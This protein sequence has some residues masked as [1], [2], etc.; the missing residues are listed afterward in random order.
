MPN[1]YKAD[2]NSQYMV[3]PGDTLYTIAVS[4][5]IGMDELFNTNMGINP[6]CLIVGQKLML[7][8]NNSSCIYHE[9]KQNDTLYK[10][11]RHYNVTVED[12]IDANSGIDPMNLEIGATICIPVDCSSE[13]YIV[14]ADDS[15]TSILTKFQVSCG[16]LI[17][18]NQD[19]DPDNIEEGDEICIPHYTPTPPCVE[20]IP[21]MIA[22]GEDLQSTAEKFNT[23]T[24]KLLM[25]NPNLAPGE[26]L[27]GRCICVPV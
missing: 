6:Y 16:A 9:I 24:D 22:D 2:I 27:S 4:H 21:Y 20:G 26:F 13:I 12:I 23:S 3:V 8:L 10:I 1:N 7:P 18:A 25:I 15:L 14:E 5:N 17:D 19:F 11:A